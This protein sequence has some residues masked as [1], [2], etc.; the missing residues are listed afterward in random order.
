MTND[1]SKT[2]T[3]W[4]L[5]LCM[6]STG[7]A[8][9]VIQYLIATA[10]SFILGSS[11]IIFSIVIG[12]ML[13]AMGVSGWI[14]EHISN[15]NLVMKF[16]FIEA[17]LFILGSFS[18]LILFWSYGHMADHFNLVLYSLTI[19]VGLLIGLEI[20]IVIRMIEEL[21]VPL[22]K[23]LKLV[24]GLDY[25]GAMLFMLAWV[26]ILLPKVPIHQIGFIVS[27]VNFLIATLTLLFIYIANGKSMSFKQV[28][29][30]LA[31]T[32][33]LCLTYVYGVSN[34]NNWEIYLEQKLY[35]DP[36]I[37]KET[38]P[39][40]H[41]VL[42]KN[43]KSYCGTDYR[44]YINGNT[45]FSSCDEAIYHENLIVPAMEMVGTGRDVLILGGGDGMALRDVLKYKPE[46]VHLV[47][48]DEKMVDLSKNNK[49][50]SMLNERAFDSSSVVKKGSLASQDGGL[51]RD[52]FMQDASGKENHVAS[53]KRMHIDAGVF[54]RSLKVGYDVIIIDLPDPS[55][56]ELSKLYT[57]GFF[58]SLRGHL[59]ADGVMVIQSTSPFYAPEVYLEIGRTI[60]AS[61]YETFGYHDNVPSFGDWGFW[62]SCP[63]KGCI[64]KVVDNI[65]N[66]EEFS[67]ETKHLT[68]ELLRANMKFGKRNNVDFFESSNSDNINTNTNPTLFMRYEKA[69]KG[70]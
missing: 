54:V 59:S 56:V 33:P 24:L 5:G 25:V 40:Q 69:W 28:A 2:I 55:S 27:G 1:S 20:P 17:S 26:F 58:S 6:L 18:A 15:K 61:G 49:Y 34:S 64:N 13:G 39:Y 60:E 57:R 53:V 51:F 44:L 10:T 16:F 42:T 62:I 35:D 48:L 8:G 65:I 70:Y 52:I 22:K 29:T 45:Q 19:S 7:G 30:S 23:N 50:L 67:I 9:L 14:Q 41:I 36:I 21:G 47:D 32:I 63:T 37:L 43:E 3:P 68:P 31:L 4:L 46:N 66:M 11:I 38:T 12:L